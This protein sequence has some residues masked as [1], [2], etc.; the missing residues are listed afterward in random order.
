MS[1]KT[2]KAWRKHVDTTDVDKYLDRARQDE[3]LG[4]YASKKDAELFAID[5]Q[6]TPLPKSVKRMLFKSQE[7]KCFAILR[8]RS[9]VPD[10][11]SVRNRVRTKEERMNA[12][13][14]KKIALRRSKGI[15]KKKEKQSLRDNEEYR[16]RLRLRKERK[17]IEFQEDIW[18]KNLPTRHAAPDS[19]WMTSDVLRHTLAHRGIKKRQVPSSVQ[20]K[21]SA[22]PA[23]EVP[24]EGTSYNPALE[25]HQSLLSQ[26]AEKE[27]RLLKEEAH[28]S[29]VTSKMFSKT[30]AAE[31]EE[32]RRKELSEGLDIYPE[33][34]Q[35]KEQTTT[36]NPEDEGDESANCKSVNPVVKREKKT[37]KQRRK[38][39]EQKDLLRQQQEKKIDKRKTS[40]I[41]RL[42]LIGKQ[43]EKAEQQQ[44]KLRQQK[45]LK[46]AKK[47]TETRQLGKLKFEKDD[48][49]FAM[50][51]D[52][53][54]NLRNTAPVG[55]LLRDRFKS[56][57][58]RNI[59][60]PSSMKK[61]QKA[62]VKRFIKP[63]H[64]IDFSKI[65]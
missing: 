8:E 32:N 30:N 58:E 24:H 11:I 40:D 56:L 60:S 61:I 26:V 4:S 21:T 19:E 44:T 7:P 29:R 49:D 36:L 25:A 37:R 63:E 3:R 28:L 27:Q 20:K 10:P 46:K 52:L 62:K 54:G 23:I 57:Q 43:L 33:N 5:K 42:K 47:H 48:P 50:M 15:L 16:K 18:E 45:L 39:R 38:Q 55:N 51:D 6:S 1:K 2:K 9:A 22:L 31:A 34:M 59:L 35:T 53:T 65:K 41:Y 12:L 64:K 14:V 17:R 13:L